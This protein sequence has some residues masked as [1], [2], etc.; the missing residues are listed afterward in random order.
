MSLKI[1]LRNDYKKVVLRKIQEKGLRISDNQNED[2]RIIQYFSYLRKKSYE[3]PHQVLKSQEFTCPA[4]VKKGFEKL[5]KVIEIGG[6]ITPYFNR[7]AS[8]LE[9]YDYLF[10]DWGIMHF[11][12]GEELIPGQN[13]VKRGDPVLFTYMHDDKVYFLNI[14]SHG[15]WSNK[16][17]IQLMYNNWS[18]LL[19]NYKVSDAYD[20][21][22]EPDSNE[23]K[24]L[25]KAGSVYFFSI[26]DN[27]GGKVILMPPGLG[28]TTARTALIDTMAFNNT[29]INLGHIQ[30]YIINSETELEEWMK[31]NGIEKKQEILLEL[32]DFN[33]SELNLVDKHNEFT[34]NMPL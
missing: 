19:E 1:E 32:I 24:E 22:E 34:Y 26:I 11:H 15:N 4:E 13:L 29:M 30:E 8:N 2:H 3:G 20:V 16:E 10:G 5:Q 28:L 9:Q 31:E 21:K 12:L 33:P 25:R 18:E 23:I 17:V 6:D 14:Y 7:G 27:D